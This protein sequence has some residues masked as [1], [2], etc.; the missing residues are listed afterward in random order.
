MGFHDPRS[1][2][3][4]ISLLF[5]LAYLQGLG[6]RPWVQS[7]LSAAGAATSPESPAAPLAASRR[8]RAETSPCASPGGQRAPDTLRARPR[9]PPFARRAGTRTLEEQ[10]RMFPRLPSP[11]GA[12]GSNCRAWTREKNRLLFAQTHGPLCGL[13]LKMILISTRFRSLSAYCEPNLQEEITLETQ[14]YHVF[15]PFMPLHHQTVTS[16]GQKLVEQLVFPGRLASDRLSRNVCFPF[17]FV[18]NSR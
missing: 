6:L 13:A 16:W 1:T 15:V 17:I 9:A 5:A 12:L 10:G 8:I 14:G 7:V 18:F 2:P 4:P 3:T 11:P